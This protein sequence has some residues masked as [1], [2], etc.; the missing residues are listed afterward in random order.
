MPGRSG[1]RRDRRRLGRNEGQASSAQAASATSSS[2][3]ADADGQQPAAAPEA[4]PE[5]SAPDGHRHPDFGVVIYDLE[6]IHDAER[7][8]YHEK[9][10]HECAASEQITWKSR[11]QIIEFAAVDVHS[12]TRLL[13]R[14]RPEFDWADVRSPAA[15]CFAEDH[16]HDQIIKDESLPFFRTRWEEEV[17]PFL[18]RAAGSSG[19]LAMIAH[20]GDAFD[21]YV[22]DKEL[23]RLGLSDGLPLELHRFDPIRTLKTH[24][25]QDYGTCGQLA[26]KALHAQHVQHRAGG[27]LAPHQAMDD[28]LMLM[29]VLSRWLDLGTLL[30][31]EIASEICQEAG[32]V[33][34]SSALLRVRFACP[35]HTAVPGV[36]PPPPPLPPPPADEEAE[37]PSGHEFR[38]GAVEF[39][40]GV[41]WS[42]ASPWGGYECGGAG[43]EGF[44]GEEGGGWPCCGGK[45]EAPYWEPL[46]P[47]EAAA[48][49]MMQYQ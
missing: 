29:E 35:A 40:P 20:N 11:S 27:E 8:T 25:G 15:R 34:A 2:V 49:A 39:V 36:P 17:I 18:K 4:K 32:E 46:V 12:G 48:L 41:P 24:F 6:T 28:C 31:E 30:A 9:G 38:L 42:S 23:T 21:H 26:L 7:G 10:L 33:P 45:G 43:L 13:L 37:P 1:R 47:A 3:S 16:G 14:C 44:V 5:S 19:R 22:L